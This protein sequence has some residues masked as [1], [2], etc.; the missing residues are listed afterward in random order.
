MIVDLK[1]HVEIVHV[2]NVPATTCILFPCTVFVSMEC[3]TAWVV[4]CGSIL[5][6]LVLAIYTLNIPSGKLTSLL[7]MAISSGFTH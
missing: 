3:P 6:L 1:V 2:C 4:L 7:K 5:F